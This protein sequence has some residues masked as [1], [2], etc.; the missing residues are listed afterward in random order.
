MSAPDDDDRP[1]AYSGNRFLVGA[2]AGSMVMIQGLPTLRPRLTHDQALNLA[3]WLVAVVG[4]HGRFEKI[5]D[6]VE[7][8]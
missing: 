7:R 4:D 6:A 8:T 3:A 2:L 5:L 1:A